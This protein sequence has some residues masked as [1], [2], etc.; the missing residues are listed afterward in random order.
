MS[1]TCCSTVSCRHK[2]QQHKFDDVVTHHTM[3]NE[4][5]QFFMRGFR[6]D[7]HP[8]GRADGSRGRDERV[9]SGLDEPARRPA[10]RHLGAPA[11]R[12]DADARRDGLQVH[13]RPAVR[14]SAQRAVVRGELHADDVRDAVRGV[15]GQPGAGTCARSH[16]H[17]A[18]RPRAECVDVH[19]SHVCVVGHEPVRGHCRGRRVP[20]GSGARRRQR[21]CA[22]HALRHPEAT[23]AW[24]RWASS[25][26]R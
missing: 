13:G 17:P 1:A 10:A 11:D 19:G 24:R 26:P 23:A 2:E 14:L 22:Q 6:R 20:V 18:R 3:V 9:L 16:L 8:D 12:E 4:Q 5:M 7:A 21:G 15:Q 25:S